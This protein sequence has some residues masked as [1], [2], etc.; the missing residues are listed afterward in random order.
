LAKNPNYTQNLIPRQGRGDVVGEIAR[1]KSDDE[2]LDNLRAVLAKHGKLTLKL[3]EKTP[4]TPSPG[5]TGGDSDH[6]LVLISELATEAFGTETTW[7][8]YATSRC[9]AQN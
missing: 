7:R 4:N 6:F 8:R 2:L 5:S 9:F 1:N 3:I